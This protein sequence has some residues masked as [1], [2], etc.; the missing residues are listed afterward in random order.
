[1]TESD[2]LSAMLDELANAPSEVLPS[3]YWTELNAL[4]L[5][6]LGES[7]YDSFKRTLARNYFT[8]V[9]APGDPQLRFLRAALPLAR[10]ARAALKTLLVPRQSPM[11]RRQTLGYAF[12]TFLLWDYAKAQDTGGLL[13]RLEEPLV[14]SPP[15]LRS[16]G[17]L[18]SQDLANSVLEYRAMTEPPMEPD[19]LR[20]VLEL[21]AGYGRTAYVFLSLL[22][23][24]RYLVV[25][26][27]PALYVA[28]RYLTQ[29]FPGRAAFR[30]RPFQDYESVRAE[31]EAA[32]IAFLLP[33]QLDLLPAR[34]VDL[35]LNISSFHEM[36]LE[37][38]RYY[39]DRIERL[40]RGHLYLK[41]WR[42]SHIPG[43]GVVIREQDY[44]IRREWRPIYH[45][46]CRVQD[47]F[48]E[49]LYDLG[50]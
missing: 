26:I 29:V 36:R 23:H 37:Q 45:R 14:G 40:T 28:E 2:R 19:G 17:R 3:T 50:R 12:L 6:Q 8:W 30:F 4:N 9:A 11:T 10:V 24:V 48:F 7:G 39:F 32:Q 46:A 44:P 31:L 41:E 13:D 35:F 42:E 49:A 5:R 33:H 22:P 15:E 16:G 27:P 20:T 34:S 47:R 18:I 25:D 21:G 1:M 38:I 43:D